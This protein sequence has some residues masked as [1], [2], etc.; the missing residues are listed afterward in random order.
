MLLQD[1]DEIII[2]TKIRKK[3][4]QKVK[5]YREKWQ[6][7]FLLDEITCSKKFSTDKAQNN[8]KKE[9]KVVQIFVF[10]LVNFVTR[11]IQNSITFSLFNPWGQKSMLDKKFSFFKLYSFFEFMHFLFQIP[12]F[13]KIIALFLVWG[14]NH[15]GKLQFVLK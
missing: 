6:Y 2:E 1:G 7:F 8:I 13:G 5:K 9:R 11:R 12:S 3:T 4:Q 15:Y 10:F 14:T